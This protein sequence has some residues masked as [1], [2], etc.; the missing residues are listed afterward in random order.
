[1]LS[2]ITRLRNG[3]EQILPNLDNLY[4]ARG[5]RD[6]DDWA[7]SFYQSWLTDPTNH[8]YIALNRDRKVCLTFLY[9]VVDELEKA[10]D[11]PLFEQDLVEEFEVWRIKNILHVCMIMDRAQALY[12]MQLHGSPHVGMHWYSKR[13]LDSDTFYARLYP[14]ERR[15]LIAMLSTTNYPGSG[16]M[17]RRLFTL[18]Y[19][20]PALGLLNDEKLVRWSRPVIAT[21]ANPPPARSVATSATNSVI[22]TAP[23]VSVL[24]HPQAAPT[25]NPS[26]GGARSHI[27]PPAN[28]P[29]HGS[30][31]AQL[32]HHHPSISEEIR[33]SIL[34]MVEEYDGTEFQTSLTRLYN[35]QRLSGLHLEAWARALYE[36]LCHDPFDQRASSLNQDRKK[37]LSLL[38]KLVDLWESAG[39]SK[40]FE[41]AIDSLFKTRRILRILGVC[42]IMDRCQ[43]LYK[44]ELLGSAV[45]GMHWYSK[46]HFNDAANKAHLTH[47][48]MLMW[49]HILANYSGSATMNKR[50]YRLIYS[51]ELKLQ[52]NELMAKWS[53]PCVAPGLA[54]TVP[55][56]YIPVAF[57]N[58]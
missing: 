38:Y 3:Y 33:Q 2:A 54:S 40:E 34:Q 41:K 24:P 13:H 4:R 35:D 57:H 28:V 58:L 37:C 30:H 11:K 31:S 1:M 46:L 16:T 55:D 47:Q 22:P 50:L 39:F 51:E 20:A 56:I 6:G 52:E 45:V 49:N 25:A 19:C 53:K 18:I 26:L 14:E 43:S 32:W 27:A 42:L 7:T 17:N 23:V 36:A 21:F 29:G 8:V 48:E 44:M 10:D 9:S 15:E 12:K 5:N